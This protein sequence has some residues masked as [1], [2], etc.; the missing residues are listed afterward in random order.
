MA[1]VDEMKSN[2]SAS[3]ASAIPT[4]VMASF[5][6]IGQVFFQENA[7]TGV[8]FVI[9]IALSSPVMAVGA[10][11]GAAIGTATAWVLKFDRAEVIAGIY[12]FNSTLVGIAT[13]FFF[14]PSAMSVGLLVAGCVAAALV[15]W[16]ARR[17][18]PFPTYTA[19]FIVMTWCSISWD[20]QWERKRSSRAGRWRKSVSCARSPTG[21]AR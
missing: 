10:I 9:G 5:R 20:W 17:Y 12:G 14:R 6:G 1:N 3:L 2:A 15:T 8:L 19:P 4:P 18:L 13:F 21:S 7:L 16:L 11:V